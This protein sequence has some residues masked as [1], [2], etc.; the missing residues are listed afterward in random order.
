MKNKLVILNNIR[1]F[2]FFLPFGM[3]LFAIDFFTKWFALTFLDAP[4]HVFSTPFGVDLFLQFVVNKGGAWGSFANYS[5]YLLVFRLFVIAFLAFYF[6]TN[7]QKKRFGF[8]LYILM[9]GACANVFDFFVYGHVID[10]IHFIFWGHS[11][12]I[13]NV[14]DSLIC[15]GGLGVCLHFLFEKKSK[16]TVAS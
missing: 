11:Y 14:A 9:V 7:S 5:N 1:L 3:A 6:F 12:G 15:L 10:M 8:C 13:F 16:N 2:F 4:M